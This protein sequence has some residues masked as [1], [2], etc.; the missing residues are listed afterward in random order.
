MKYL[1]LLLTLYLPWTM[2][3]AEP[4]VLVDSRLVPKNQVLVGGTV[5]FEVDVLVDTWFTSSPQ[6]PKLEIPGAVVSVPDSQATHLTQQRDG[7]TFFGIRFTYRI[8][9]QQ[10]QAFNIAPLDIQVEAGQGSAPVTVQ[11]QAQSFTATK[12]VGARNDEHALVAEDLHYKQEIV[13]SHDPLRVGDSVSRQLSVR[14]VGAQAMLIPA[15]QIDDVDGLKQYA[16]TPDIKGLDDGRG[17]ISGGLRN[18]TLVYVVKKPGEYTLPALDLKWWDLN[19]Q[20]HTAKVPEVR[21]KAEAGSDYNAPF[22]IRDDL[23]QL[24]QNSQLHIARHWLLLVGLAVFVALAVVFGRPYWQRS[25]QQ[26][27]QRR[28]TR[29]QAWLAS[30]EYA[31][32]QLQNKLND[33]SVPYDALYLWLKRSVNANTVQGVS[34]LLPLQFREPLLALIQSEYVTPKGALQ[35]A[36]AQKE[37]LLSVRKELNKKQTPALIAGELKPLNPRF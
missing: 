5:M 12:P 17:D 4:S 7:K 16:Q 25:K 13:R 9:P 34:E 30:P 32:R 29:R 18:D 2:A 23:R 10:A 21:F 28:E 35:S 24:G 27:L 6:L 15:P 20:P 3:T 22:S 19:G 11:T 1:I 26:F 36:A 14:A 37:L 8:T 31:W 33:Q